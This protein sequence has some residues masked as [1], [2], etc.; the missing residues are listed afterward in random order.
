M[1]LELE[2]IFH[3]ING[4]FDFHQRVYKISDFRAERIDGYFFFLYFSANFYNRLAQMTAKSSVDSVRREMIANMLIP[5]PTKVEQSAIATALDDANAL[6]S[7]LERLIDKKKAIKQG[8]MQDLLRLKKGWK[9]KT[10]KEI[11]ACLDN[12]RIP[13]NEVERNKMKGNYPYCGANG[14]VDYIKEWR[15][16]GDVILIAEDGGYFDEYVTRPIAYQMNGK[17][18][19]NNHV[20]ILKAKPHYSQEFI[21][22]SLV[23]K[24]ILSYLANGTRAK[25]NKSE[26]SKIE[27]PIPSN[28][29]A[30]HQIAKILS[31]MD[32]EIALLEKKLEKQMLIKQG[33]MQVL[34]TGKIR[35]V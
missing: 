18:W 16:E 3:Y 12:L 34:L 19:V 9:L 32:S 4:K 33:M 28:E 15:I 21:F 26:M 13:L 17:Y 30:Q 20:H 11:T 14:I 25:L 1:A 27:I 23:H 22:Y 10:I 7:S 8:T 2:K 31:D 35:L 24:N 5:L 6:I 29:N